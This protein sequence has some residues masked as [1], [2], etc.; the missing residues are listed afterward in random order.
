LYLKLKV[1]IMSRFF[2]FISILII[3]VS[4][5]YIRDNKI[6]RLHEKF[7]SS[8]ASVFRD[9]KTHVESV[10]PDLEN[11]RFYCEKPDK[12]DQEYINCHANFYLNHEKKE[13]SV[14]CDMNQ[15]GCIQI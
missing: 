7:V 6:E 4:F 9:F 14:K 11:F 8:K 10:Y 5:Q 1:I 13:F 15:N 12:I 2:I 3:S